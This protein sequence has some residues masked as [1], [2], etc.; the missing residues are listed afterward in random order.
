MN[1]IKTAK[2]LDGLLRALQLNCCT[3]H[4][5]LQQKQR[6]KSLE[7]FEDSP[8]SVLVATD[9]AARGLDI[10][11]IQYVLHYDVARSPQVK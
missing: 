2:R 5:Q 6:I 10:S 4:A 9:V 7:R 8:I 1:S 11:R 3:L